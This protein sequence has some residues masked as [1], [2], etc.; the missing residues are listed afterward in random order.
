MG[1]LCIGNNEGVPAII[2]FKRGTYRILVIDYDGT[3]ITQDYLDTGYTFTLPTPPVHEGL[4]FEEWSCAF[5]IVNNQVTVTDSDIIIGPIYSTLSEK[6]EF[7]ISLNK[8]TGKIVHFNSDLEKDWGDGTVNTETEHTYS[9]Y[10]DY[11]IKCALT[12]INGPVITEGNAVLTEIRFGSGLTSINNVG[13]GSFEGCIS[14]EAV[15][16]PNTLQAIDNQ[17]FK[18]CWCLETL[19]LPT[20]LITLGTYTFSACIRLLYVVFSKTLQTIGSG[21]FDICD[22]LKTAILPNSVTFLGE[23]VFSNNNNLSKIRLSTGLVSISDYCFSDCTALESISVPESIVT[24]GQSCFLRCSHLSHLILS[25]NITTIK[26]SAFESCVNIRELRLP[27]G[28]LTLE[29][30]VLNG[31]NSIHKII[32]GNSLT[33]IETNAFNNLGSCR[34]YDFT[35]LEAVPTLAQGVFGW[36]NP[37]TKILVPVTLEAQWKAATNWSEYADYIYGV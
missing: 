21:C 22:D 32:F 1:K 8:I 31:M 36:L 12:T 9:Q 26:S 11:T 35:E 28:L 24:L 27:N 6:S 5:P 7:D 10:G 16:F 13:G 2:T 4:V 25:H 14:L 20:G 29:A 33:S 15:S 17:S 3:I 19:I 37:Q 34:I 18:D 30:N 23:Y